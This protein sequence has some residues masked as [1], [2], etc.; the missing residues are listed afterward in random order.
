[1]KAVLL[2][3]TLMIIQS[4]SSDEYIKKRDFRLSNN[5]ELQD[6]YAIIIVKTATQSISTGALKSRYGNGF[7]EMNW[8]RQNEVSDCEE[9]L[10]F[11]PYTKKKTYGQYVYYRARAG[12]YYLDKV[13][14][15]QNYSGNVLLLPF[16]FLADAGTYGAFVSPNFN[17]SAFGWNKKLNAPNFTSFETKPGEIVYIGDLYF[18]F[19]KQKYWIR[20]KI[21][22]DVQDKYDEAK[23]YFREQFPEYRNKPIIKRLA[24]PGVMLDNYDAGI[25]W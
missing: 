2:L 15:K 14:E 21:N 16:K 7:T 13:K 18:T 6:G 9:I 24:Q 5:R 19:I 22:F 20:G 17:T 10:Y 1:M 11:S 3:L 8:C 4:C 25:F 23:K 12:K